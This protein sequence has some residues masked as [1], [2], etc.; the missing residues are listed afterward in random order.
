M[1]CGRNREAREQRGVVL[2]Q[3]RASGYRG[4]LVLMTGWDTQRV[5]TDEHSQL[6][7]LVLEK[8][9][10]GSDLVRAIDALLA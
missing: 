3:L 9:F 4:K 10:L 7:D 1:L 8:P 6:C 5:D 2:R